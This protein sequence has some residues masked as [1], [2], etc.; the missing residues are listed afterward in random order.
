MESNLEGM[1]AQAGYLVILADLP[2]TGKVLCKME[3]RFL[4]VP[5]RL[6]EEHVS[7]IHFHGWLSSIVV[8]AD[9]AARLSPGTEVWWED[10]H[11]EP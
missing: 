7:G 10:P 8:S 11:Q 9:N 2:R 1:A 3:N 5:Y 4:P 6:I